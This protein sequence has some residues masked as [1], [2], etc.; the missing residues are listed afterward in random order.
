MKQGTGFL[1]AQVPL[2]MMAIFKLKARKRNMSLATWIV[3]AC[4]AYERR[5]GV[6]KERDATW[7]DSGWRKDV[8]CIE[9]SQMHDPAE[10][11]PEMF[12]DGFTPYDA[13]VGRVWK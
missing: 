4:L 5:S 10:A 7:Y 11:H 8:A 12:V 1:K 3:Q 6:V 13:G 9:C 2:D